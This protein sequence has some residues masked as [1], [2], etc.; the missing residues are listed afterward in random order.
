MKNTRYRIPFLAL[1]LAL[2]IT[3]CRDKT[4]Q[5]YTANVPVLQ[6]L[7]AFRNTTFAMASPRALEHP[8]KIYIY[9]NLLLV[10]ELYQ[11]IH[12]YDNSNPATPTALGFLPIM[13]NIDMG[14][15]NNILYADAYNDLLSFDITDPM[16]PTLVGRNND[17]FNFTAVYM[18]PGFD[19]G[20]PMT[21]LA[22]GEGVVIGWE[23]A[24]VTVDAEDQCYWFDRNEVFLDASF[25]GGN[26]VSF[27]GGT[28][29]AGSTARFA[30]VSD[31]LY[32]VA[33]TQMQVF[34]IAG[35]VSFVRTVTFSTTAET[36]FPYNDLLFIGT[37]TGMLIYDI[38]NTGDPSFISEYDHV[39]ACDPVVVDGNYAYVTL[40][41]GNNCFGSVNAAEVIDIS[42]IYTPIAVKSAVMTNP[43]GL[44]VEG[45]LLFIC[46]G[47]TGLK[48]YDKT[49]PAQFDSHMLSNFTDI[50][51]NDVIAYNN[52][53]MMTSEQGIYQY[54]YTDAGDVQFLSLIPI[55]Q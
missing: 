15:R 28:G 12:F 50:T 45:N 31:K 33:P 22:F 11:G 5:T 2:A 55:Q 44:A 10:N 23:L 1:L 53:L 27:I 8:G 47:P 18:L 36:I 9:Q 48:V 43:R 13:A 21:P 6:S 38:S 35:D 40:R 4:V 17:V 20:Y 24:E 34:D 19:D 39:T 29:K 46:D 7:D 52:H 16:H 32:T 54:S 14:I 30:I 42:N 25:S 51:A 37:N 26:Q 49:D 41:T 3:S